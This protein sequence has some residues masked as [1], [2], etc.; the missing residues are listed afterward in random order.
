MTRSVRL[1]GV[2]ARTAQR[3][4]LVIGRRHRQHG[5]GRRGLRHRHRRHRRC[6]CQSQRHLQSISCAPVGG[7]AHR[8]RRR[9]QLVCNGASIGTG[10]AGWSGRWTRG[11]TATPSSTSW[12][13]SHM[14]ATARL[15]VVVSVTPTH[16]IDVATR[17]VG[18]TTEAAPFRSAPCRLPSSMGIH[19]AGRGAPSSVSAPPQPLLVRCRPCSSVTTTMTTT[20]TTTTLTTAA[21]RSTT[22]TVTAAGELVEVNEGLHSSVGSANAEDEAC[23]Q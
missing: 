2:G 17:V 3:P 16:G 5:V 4:R 22:T 9:R 11:P 20:T 7:F 21:S 13:P 14:R 18:L 8:S 6:H 19:A 15:L 1:I 10:Q 12:G 23:T